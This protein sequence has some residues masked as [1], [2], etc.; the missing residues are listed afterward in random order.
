MLEAGIAA[1]KAKLAEMKESVADVTVTNSDSPDVEIKSG[2]VCEA[3]NQTVE[4]VIDYKTM[5]FCGECWRKEKEAEEYLEQTRKARVEEANRM[6]QNT[7]AL[8]KLTPEEVIQSRPDY[9]NAE[10]QSHIELINEIEADASIEN[11]FFEIAT[12]LKA[13]LEYT[14]SKLIEVRDI[15]LRHA[16]EERAIHVTLNQ[17]ANKL[18]EEEKEKLQIQDINYKPAQVVVKPKKEKSVSSGPS[19][20]MKELTDK[21]AAEKVPAPVIKVIMDRNKGFSIDRAITEYRTM[22]AASQNKG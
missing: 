8:R 2:P 5:K 16:S 3:C 21:C 18:R 22:L 19:I 20:G 10:V 17:L 14:Q 4:K 9:F 6:T 12:R 15:E 11:K 7:L 13:R 1:H